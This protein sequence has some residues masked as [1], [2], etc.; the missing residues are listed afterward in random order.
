MIIIIIKTNKNNIIKT[1]KATK[2]IPKKTII[3]KINTTY[4]K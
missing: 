3:T 4:R 1:T 2:K